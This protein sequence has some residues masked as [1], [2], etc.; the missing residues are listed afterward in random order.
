MSLPPLMAGW[1][2]EEGR[3]R[4]ADRLISTGAP[5]G[6]GLL[7]SGASLP[8]GLP[9]PAPHPPPHPNWQQHTAVQLWRYAQLESLPLNEPG[10]RL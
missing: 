1:L 6:P 5:W 2:C 10:G 7:S 9:S 4:G 3:A 8:A